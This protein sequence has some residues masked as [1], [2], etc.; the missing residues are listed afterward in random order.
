V[1]GCEVHDTSGD[2]DAQVRDVLVDLRSGRIHEL[3]LEEGGR[4]LKLP[5]QRISAAGSEG[6]LRLKADVPADR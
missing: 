5:M 6:A 3:V 2:D 1:L 4:T